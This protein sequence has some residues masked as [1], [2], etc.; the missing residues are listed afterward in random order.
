MKI[1]KVRMSDGRNRY[2][3]EFTI[4]DLHKIA[5]WRTLHQHKTPEEKTRDFAELLENL[6]PEETPFDREHLFV[7]TY[8]YSVG[9]TMDRGKAECPKC[10]HISDMVVKFA[11]AEERNLIVK[12][13][14]ADGEQAFEVKYK[15]PTNPGGTDGGPNTVIDLRP[16]RYDI[17]EFEEYG[18]V[19]DVGDKI[20]T[21]S[22]E[23]TTFTGFEDIKTIYKIDKSE[24]PVYM[25]PSDIKKELKLA[26]DSFAASQVKLHSNSPFKSSVH[27]NCMHRGCGYK[28]NRE[29][30]TLM[31]FIET[32]FAENSGLDMLRA[33][34][35][36]LL[37][38]K[39]A[40]NFLSYDEMKNMSRLEYSAMFGVVKAKMEA[41]K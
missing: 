41:K 36:T 38:L 2:I 40:G 12:I 6:W 37:S 24:I 23:L 27:F 3:D 29:L 31:E 28:V 16:V 22:N 7:V 9:K 26:L 18:I 35:S 34:Y 15:N 14:A 10:Q 11:Q 8:S 5:M 39:E 19:P 30:S 13:P 17:N 21:T 33:D 1:H 4:N 25:L 32:I 20:I